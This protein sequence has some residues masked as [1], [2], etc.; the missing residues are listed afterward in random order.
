LISRRKG[1]CYT[2]LYGVIAYAFFIWEES[3]YKLERRSCKCKV[4]ELQEKA[5]NGKINEDKFPF[6]KKITPKK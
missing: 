5:A 1:I 2:R 3:F 4:G 6:Y